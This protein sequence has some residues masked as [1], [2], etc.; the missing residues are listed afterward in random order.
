MLQS[1]GRFPY[2]QI[3]HIIR[4]ITI[5]NIVKRFLAGLCEYRIPDLYIAA[6]HRHRT[7]QDEM[8]L[9]VPTVWRGRRK[10]QAVI[11]AL[12]MEYSVFRNSR[13]QAAWL[14]VPTLL[15]YITGANA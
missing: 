11:V 2:L 14:S 3:L 13:F 1:S 8:Q 12:L 9:A 5:T 4:S 6:H 15:M 7:G 10:T